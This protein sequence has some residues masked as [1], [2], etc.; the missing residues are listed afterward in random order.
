MFTLG[1]HAL[2]PH[3]QNSAVFRHTV[4]NLKLCSHSINQAQAQ[5]C[6]IVGK[7]LGNQRK[8]CSHKDPVLNL[9][10]KSRPCTWARE[11]SLNFGVGYL[12]KGVFTL[13]LSLESYPGT[14]PEHQV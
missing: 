11:P 8:T 9:V 13:V 1:A 14:V 5:Y 3:R 10:P 2:E 7:A 12:K 4:P 6:E